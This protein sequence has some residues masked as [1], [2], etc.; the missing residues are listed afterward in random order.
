MFLNT[1]ELFIFETQ[2]KKI[3]FLKSIKFLLGKEEN[4]KT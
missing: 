3:T 1:L 2:E 4:G